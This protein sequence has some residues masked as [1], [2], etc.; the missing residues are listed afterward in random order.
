MKPWNNKTIK[1]ILCVRT[2]NM[3]DLLMSVPAM[4]ALKETFSCKLTLLTSPMAEEAANY[5]A[6]IDEWIAYN[7]PWNRVEAVPEDTFDLI[8]LLNSQKFDACVIFTV[9]SQNPLPAALL[10]F[11]AGIPKRLAYCRENPYGLLT[12]WMPDKEPYSFIQHQVKR[13]LDLVKAVGATTSDDRL[14]LYFSEKAWK[15][16]K[17]KLSLSGVNLKGKWIVMH[18]GVSEKKRTYPAEHWIAAGKKLRD[19]FNTQ[20]LFTG[21]ATET[22]T[23]SDIC[24]KTGKDAFDL[25]GKLELEEFMALIGHSPL[26]ISVNTATIHIAAALDTPVIVLYALTNPQHAPWKA[27]G[28]VLLFH[29]PEELRSKNEIVKDAYKIF[30]KDIPS[31]ASPEDILKAADELLNTKNEMSFPEIIG[32]NT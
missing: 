18:A 30:L 1:K 9:Y 10:A 32:L 15:G 7:S 3:G 28:K 17:K 25:S 29:P 5:I 2:D 11:M 22:D 13:D 19:Q 6:E 23:I 26:V 21:T 12:D 24:K 31:A 27:R 8:S 4:R 20:L 14:H 16:T